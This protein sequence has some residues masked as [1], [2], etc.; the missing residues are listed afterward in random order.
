MGCAEIQHTQAVRENNKK[1]DDLSG[2]VKLALQKESYDEPSSQLHL[3]IACKN[4]P[5]TDTFSKTDP[6]AVVYLQNNIANAWEI[7]GYTEVITNTLNPVFVTSI[8]MKY[9]FEEKQFVKIEVYD[10]D[11]NDYK[12]LSKQEY[13]GY[14]EF[15]IHEL[16]RSKELNLNLAGKHKKGNISLYADMSNNDKESVVLDT[17]I[18]A[19]NVSQLMII[20]SKSKEGSAEWVPVYK[21]EVIKGNHL[22]VRFDK[23]TL[24]SSVQEKP[25]LFAVFEF[26]SNGSHVK[27]GEAQFTYIQLLESKASIKLSKGA[28]NILSCKKEVSVSFLDFVM[29]GLNISLCIGVDFTLSNIEPH[30]PNSLH[31]FDLGISIIRK[32]PIFKSY[33]ICRNYIRML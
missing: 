26:K 4:L 11:N 25:Y 14:T 18:V 17:E 5:D 22:P 33:S 7:V 16:I 20:I 21:T 6:F 28:F 12:N 10:Q 27:L 13:L 19:C 32:Q 31:Y 29:K 15:Y 9:L 2:A 1:D 24:P 3:H 30:K 23:I 8:C